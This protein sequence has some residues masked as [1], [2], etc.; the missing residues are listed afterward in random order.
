[1]RLILLVFIL[2]GINCTTGS[3]LKMKDLTPVMDA[4]KIKTIREI[5]KGSN[6]EEVAIVECI[7]YGN[8]VKQRNMDIAVNCLKEKASMVG[9]T[10]IRLLLDQCTFGKDEIIEKKFGSG[11]VRDFKFKNNNIYLIGVALR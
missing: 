9:G 6:F 8:F 7:G 2:F 4:S 3:V 10:H 1:M 11:V 5:P